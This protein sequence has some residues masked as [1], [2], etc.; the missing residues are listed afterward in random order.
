[1]GSSRL[2]LSTVS[3]TGSP[4]SVSCAASD[5]RSDV[6]QPTHLRERL[7][8]AVLDPLERLGAGGAG[9]AGTGRLK[10]DD[11]QGVRD[12]VVQ[13]PGEP[14]ALLRRGQGGPR[15][16]GGGTLTTALL[17]PPTMDEDTRQPCRHEQDQEEGPRPQLARLTTADVVVLEGV[18]GISGH[19]DHEAGCRGAATRVGGD[20]ISGEADHQDQLEPLR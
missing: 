10:H 4:A 13:L 17:L 20:R 12:D 19:R 2:P 8:A 9:G 14:A 5:S 18:A 16:G 1:V 3:S 15:L 11:A 6:E 7:A